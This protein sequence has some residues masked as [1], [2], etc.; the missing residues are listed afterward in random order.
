MKRRRGAEQFSLCRLNG[1][2]YGAFVRFPVSPFGTVRA[3]G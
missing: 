1:P 3:A 2:Q